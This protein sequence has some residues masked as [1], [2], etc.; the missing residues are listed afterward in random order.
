MSRL[1]KDQRGLTLAE[2]LASIGV[3]AIVGGLLSTTVF[4][5]IQSQSKVLNDGFAIN[6]L[7]RG[8]A[9]IST[10]IKAAQST[11]LPIDS[12]PSATVTLDWTDEY[13]DVVTPHSSSYALTGTLLL[14]NYDGVQSVV[15]RKVVSVSFSLTGRAIDAQIEVQGDGGTTKTMSLKSVMTPE[16]T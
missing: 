6:E 13:N 16:A 2:L 9:A 3:L 11:D 10:D 8:L 15:A 14:R 4:Q 12:S 7:T 1:L 5:T